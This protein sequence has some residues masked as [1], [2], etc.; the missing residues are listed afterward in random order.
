MHLLIAFFIGVSA[1]L[2]W[3]CVHG[4]DAE[5][6]AAYDRILE[7]ISMGAHTDKIEDNLSFETVVCD[8]FKVWIYFL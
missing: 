5:H 6:Q 2:R 4:I 8:A 7:C 3:S 1:A